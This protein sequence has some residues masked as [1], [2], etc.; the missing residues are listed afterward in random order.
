[1]LD[2]PRGKGVPKTVKMK[3][4]LFQ[5]CPSDGFLERVREPSVENLLSIQHIEGR[6]IQRND[7]LPSLLRSERWRALNVNE[8]TLQVDILPSEV[9]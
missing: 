5:L 9:Q 2:K 6:V 1:M 7:E 4:V 3:P 8:P